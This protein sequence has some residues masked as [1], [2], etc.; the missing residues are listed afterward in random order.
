MSFVKKGQPTVRNKARA[1]GKGADKPATNDSFGKK[2]QPPVHDKAPSSKDKG[3]TAVS[4]DADKTSGYTDEGTGKSEYDPADG[5]RAKSVADLRNASK[6]ITERS[7]AGP[8]SPTG[9]EGGEQGKTN[10]S[11]NSTGWMKGGE[12]PLD[13]KSMKKPRAAADQMSGSDEMEDPIDEDEEDSDQTEEGMTPQGKSRKKA[14]SLKDIKM[15]LAKMG[16]P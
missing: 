2:G 8:Y 3:R 11:K 14:K 15:A 5:K 6:L 9:S 10:S 16:K 12:G 7:D 4:D 13:K 1:A